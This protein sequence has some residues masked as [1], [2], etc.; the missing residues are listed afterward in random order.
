MSSASSQRAWKRLLTEQRIYILLA[1]VGIGMALIAPRFLTLANFT[2]IMKGMSLALPA[3]IGFTMVMIAGKMD[4]SVGSSITLGGMMTI[5]LQPYLGWGGSVAAALVCGLAVGLVN[6]FLVAKVKVDSFIVTLGTMIVTQGLIYM[7]CQGGTLAARSF[8]FGAWMEM[9]LVPLLTPRVL[10]VLLLV[11][12]FEFLMQRTRMGRNVY[13]VGGNSATAW[14]SGVAVDRTVIGVF[15]VSGVLSCLGGAL[16]GVGINAALPT[17]GANSL[18]EVVAAVI[19]GGTAMSGGK[20]SVLKSMV[21]LLTLTMLYNG[22]ECMGAGWEVRKIA[23]GLVLGA[24]VLYDAV[25]VARHR[26]VCGQRHELMA[27]L[28]TIGFWNRG[29]QT[30][31]EEPTM[32][33]KDSTALAITVVGSVACVAIVAIFAMVFVLGRPPVV[34]NIQR[35][36]APSVAVGAAR[37]EAAGGR[38]SL[39]AEADAKERDVALLKSKDN[40]L[41]ILSAAAKTIPPRPANPEALPEE[42]PLHWY[43]MEYAGWGVKKVNLPKSPVDGPGGKR[44]VFLKA[45]DHPYWKAVQTGMEKVAQVYGMRLSQK[46]ANG[47]INIQSQ[48]VDQCLNERPDMVIMGAV[49]AKA[50]VPLLRKLNEAGIPV[51]AINLLPAPEAHQYI[52]AWTGPD[53]WGQF[54]LLARDFAKRMNS[55]GS[56]CIVRHY[57]GWSPFFARTWSVITELRQVAPKMKM[58]AMQPTDLE[59]EKTKDVV[60]G[61]LTRFGPELKGVVSCDDSGAQVG[62]NEAV[63]NAGREDIIRV[64]AGNSKVGMDFVKEGKLHAITYQ[65]PEAD[66]AVPMK[67]AAD[68]FYGKAIPPIQYLPIAII[69]KDTVD[70]YMPAQW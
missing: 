31:E 70:Q 42:D 48:Q 38:V 56:Y 65:S 6:G 43:D 11:A 41:L 46:V 30:E 51:I 45:S 63:K 20:G 25:L 18:M 9:P 35:A 49:E 62:I 64:A 36:T 58:L 14:T 59:S 33:R 2:T 39:A 15:A 44:V 4:L 37:P 68:W 12:V 27:E 53:D 47:D 55:E 66:G 57:P 19:I 17:M 3:A 29:P 40:Q 34:Q 16:F 32:E 22:L 7:F 21:A 61:W 28:K 26:R 67:L 10:I 13:L 54:R 60:S 69:T 5:G 52:L 8:R 50:C 24:V 1:V 23:G